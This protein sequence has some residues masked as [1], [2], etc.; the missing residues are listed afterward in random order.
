[1][2]WGVRDRAEL[3]G[4]GAAHIITEPSELLPLVTAIR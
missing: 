3:A 2:L 4:A 1:V